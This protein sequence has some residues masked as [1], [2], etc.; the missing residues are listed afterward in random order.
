VLTQDVAREGLMQRAPS[1]IFIP[2]V[3]S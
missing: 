1:Y 3:C 2:Q